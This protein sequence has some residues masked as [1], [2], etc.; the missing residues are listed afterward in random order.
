MGLIRIGFMAVA[1]ST[2]MSVSA[3]ADDPYPSHP[4]KIVVP[5]SPGAGSDVAARVLANGITGALGQ[6]VVIENVLGAASVAGANVVAHAKPDGYTIL[7]TNVVPVGV[8]QN[9][10]NDMPYQLSDLMPV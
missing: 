1:I 8:I 9:F 10:R 2:A 7:T 3:Y 6:P 5:A 4:I